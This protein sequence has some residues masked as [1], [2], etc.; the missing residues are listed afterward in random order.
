MN[1]IK[2][3]AKH[4]C[5]ILWDNITNII[6]FA[7]HHLICCDNVK[8]IFAII[9]NKTCSVFKIFLK[10]VFCDVIIY[11]KH[12][13][14]K[15]ITSLDVI[16]TL[17]RQEHKLLFIFSRNKN[18]SY[19]TFSS[20]LFHTFNIFQI[21]SMISIINLFLHSLF[22]SAIISFQSFVYLH[23]TFSRDSS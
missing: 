22:F 21:L 19:S 17:K 3:D 13:K 12:V 7:I 23:F 9:Y 18:I 4:Y 8:C 1:M 10:N 14:C 6:K 5:K 16:Y 15:T 20:I 11:I 2:S